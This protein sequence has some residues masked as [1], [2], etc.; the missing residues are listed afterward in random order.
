MTK[1]KKKSD[2]SLDDELKQVCEKMDAKLIH[3]AEVYDAMSEEYQSLSRCFKDGHFNL[4]KARYSMGTTFLSP[5]QID[6]REIIASVTTK[7][8]PGESEKLLEIEETKTLSVVEIRKKLA[9]HREKEQ[10]KIDKAKESGKEMPPFSDPPPNYPRD[11]LSWFGLLVPRNLREA[12]TD[13]RKAAECSVSIANLRSQ[14]DK[15]I[16]MYM[17]LKSQ[18]AQLKDK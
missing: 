12:K 6:E 4:S 13:F 16:E 8:P 3:I 9:A 17:D 7:R 18:K 11:P 14:I 10:A 5:L 15:E 2:A 1:T